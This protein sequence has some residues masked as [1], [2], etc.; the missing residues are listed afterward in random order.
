ML[1]RLARELPPGRL[2]EPKWDGF[3]CLA[4]RDGEE[5]DLR[6]R[7][8][9]PLARYFPEIVAAVLE[10]GAERVVLDGELLVV[11]HGVADF[12]ALLSRLHPAASRVARLSTEAPAL[13][14]AF[15]VLALGGADLRERPFG[16]RRAVLERALAV[17]PP[18]IRITPL[19][20]DVGH[21][22]GWL[23]LG[24]GIDGVVAKDPASPYCVGE[25]AM[26]K[27]KRECAADCVVAGF[28]L[29]EDR[30][31]SSLLL[32]L[33]DDAGAL[34]HVGVAASFARARRAELLATLRPHV[35][36]LAGHPWEHGFL[37]GGSPMG[38]M[39]GAAAR[40]VPEM[41]LDWVP[42]EPE[43]VCEVA[44]DHFDVD[45]FRHPARFRRWRPDRDAR[46]CTFEQLA[47]PETAR[48]LPAA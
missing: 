22:A 45:R 15:D 36:S 32:G 6:S 13:L 41:G 11:R 46:S 38:R 5:V 31:P 33:H 14:V 27:V 44:Y 47:A 17:A 20:D 3:R 42:V 40:W 23:D 8:D 2:Y 12:D 21:A 26:T 37:V 4:F 43:L 34:R 24:G 19:T 18:R 7:N 9:R 48:L 35:R 16:E 30:T 28:R 1:A 25:R 39:K 10:L 29:F